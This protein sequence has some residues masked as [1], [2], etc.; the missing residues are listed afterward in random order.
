VEL[1][2]GSPGCD[3]LGE[4]IEWMMRNLGRP[5]SVPELA[6]LAAMSP[7]T[8]ARRFVQETGTTPQRWLTGQR[9]LLAEQLL[10]ETDET[11]DVIAER[12]GFGNATALRHHFRAWRATTPNA[13]R[14]AFAGAGSG[15]DGPAA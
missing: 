4:V 8:F 14:R 11:V 2:V 10:E 13:Y 6:G 9:I 12:S 3:T 1:P 15:P 7:R 5:M